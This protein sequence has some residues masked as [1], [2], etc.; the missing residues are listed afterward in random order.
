MCVR[1]KKTPPLFTRTACLSV[2][3]WDFMNTCA[4]KSVWKRKWYGDRWRHTQH[5][6]SFSPKQRRGAPWTH[7]L[8]CYLNNSTME[9]LWA[10]DEMVPE[11]GGK[12]K[13]IY[14][15]WAVRR[16]SI[17]PLWTNPTSQKCNLKSVPSGSRWGFT[18]R[19]LS[20]LSDARV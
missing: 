11:Q 15:T 10:R 17:V 14:P 3:V 13:P 5:V 6:L 9:S 2:C 12:C 4:R 7:A 16:K 8:V 19:R 18:S 20:R 1:Q